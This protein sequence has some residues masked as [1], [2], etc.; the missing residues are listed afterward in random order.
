MKHLSSSRQWA[1]WLLFFSVIIAA[2]RAQVGDTEAKK[3]DD[4][5]KRLWGSP[6]Q[7][8][9]GTATTVGSSDQQKDSDPASNTDNASIPFVAKGTKG[10][11]Q[12]A[13]TKY[14]T[15]P[16]LG[17]R[18]TSRVYTDPDDKLAHFD[19]SLSIELPYWEC[20]IAGSS[21]NP[22]PLQ[23]ATFRHLLAGSKPNRFSRHESGPHPQLVVALTTVEIVLNS[24]ESQTFPP[25]S[26]ILMEDVVSGGHKLQ[27][28]AHDDMTLMIL[29]LPQHYHHVG[30]DTMSLS[31]QIASMKAKD[32]CPTEMMGIP[33]FSSPTTAVARVLP[34]WLTRRR[35]FLGIVSAIFWA[36]VGDFLGKVAPY[37]L[38]IVFGGC[39]LVTAGT[40]ATVKVG[41]YAWEEVEMWNERRQMKRVEE[42]EELVNDR[43]DNLPQAE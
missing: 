9:D 4:D 26:V 12:T 8:D 24:G 39:V 30:K 5:D 3:K 40:V 13:H 32:P 2:T 37:L 11:G 1:V 16:P 15:G 22:I 17:F 38:A 28:L 19:N 31:R 7:A 42:V 33:M 34:D 35:A 6:S 25:G 36:V 10:P 18:I 41:E 27:G 14:Q 23:H 29:T 21:T 43:D 20:G